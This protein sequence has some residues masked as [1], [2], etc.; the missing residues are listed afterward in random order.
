[1]YKALSDNYGWTP[2]QIG[3]MTIAQVYWYS[4][5][6][7]AMTIPKGMNLRQAIRQLKGS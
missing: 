5:K 3:E 4:K 6:E 1:M 7:K 2:E